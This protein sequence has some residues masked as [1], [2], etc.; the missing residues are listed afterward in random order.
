MTKKKLIK[1]SLRG[2]IYTIF[3]PFKK[4]LKIDY[5]GL[6]KYLD[7]LYKS[8]ARV[9]YAMPYNSRYSQLREKEIFELNN[10]CIKKIKSYN[11]SISIVS[12]SIHGPTSLKKEMC[13]SAKENGCDIFASICREKYFEDNQILKHYQEINNCNIPII[14]HVMPFLSGY[15]SKNFDWPMSIFKKLSKL[16]NIIGI[17]EDTKS[18]IY[19]KKMIKEF[20]KKLKIIF[21][22]NKKYFLKL[23]PDHNFTYLNS[24]SIIDP[25]IE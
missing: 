14:V 1:N 5:I 13:L 6:E 11:N 2:P 8:G 23:N 21:A 15:D 19:G 22:G 18:I 16:K 17:K 25:E 24:S 4:N 7:F 9:F 20:G 3:T 12:D 10:F